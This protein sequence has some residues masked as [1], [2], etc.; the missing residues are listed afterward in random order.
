M[1]HLLHDNVMHVRDRVLS[2]GFPMLLEVNKL[3]SNG[4]IEAPFYT[5]LEMLCICGKFL[6]AEH[7]SQGKVSAR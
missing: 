7:L 1:L 3:R 5:F 4:E 6:I 2:T